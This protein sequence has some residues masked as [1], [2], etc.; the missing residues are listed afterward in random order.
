MKKYTVVAEDGTTVEVGA[1]K[2]AWLWV[3]A[4]VVAIW[5]KMVQLYAKFKS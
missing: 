5:T 4:K 3:K 2:A 1:L